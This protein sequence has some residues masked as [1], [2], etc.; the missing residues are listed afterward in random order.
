MASNA[1]KTKW[2]FQLL[3]LDAAY[4]QIKEYWW[5]LTHNWKAQE[6]F[7]K[8]CFTLF[9]ANPWYTGLCDV[10][11]YFCFVFYLWIY[12]PEFWSCDDAHDLTTPFCL[13]FSFVYVSVNTFLMSTKYPKLIFKLKA[14]KNYHK[15]NKHK[16]KCQFTYLCTKFMRASVSLNFIHAYFNFE[17]FIVS[18]V[19]LT[20]GFHFVY[21]YYVFKSLCKARDALAVVCYSTMHTLFGCC[22]GSRDTRFEM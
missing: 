2:F 17:L 1:N 13:L 15:F 10:F 19:M 22:Y 5:L 21:F 20:L 11:K 9:L 6:F 4:A 7:S 14:K 18:L 3:Q 8:N 16:P 12:F